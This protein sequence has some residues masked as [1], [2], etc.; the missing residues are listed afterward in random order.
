MV[1]DDYGKEAATDVEGC[2][3]A[4]LKDQLW[5][6]GW[7]DPYFH[8]RCAKR[9]CK[10]KV[11]TTSTSTRVSIVLKVAPPCVYVCVPAV[12]RRVQN[13]PLPAK[14]TLLDHCPVCV[15][16]TV[17]GALQA[18]RGYP[19]LQFVVWNLPHCVLYYCLTLGFLPLS[20]D[21]RLSYTHLFGSPRAYVMTSCSIV[22]VAP[23]G[24]VTYRRLHMSVVVALLLHSMHLKMFPCL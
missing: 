10:L 1:K 21:R 6:K 3:Q 16:D 11:R 4:I 22:S 7:T 18:V 19:V 5:V 8:A 23:S 2:T 14:Q 12:A 24:F 20:D 17:T 15:A 13:T 9:E